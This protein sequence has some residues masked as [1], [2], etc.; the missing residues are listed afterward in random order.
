MKNAY[1][2]FWETKEE[3][4]ANPISGKIL[5][6]ISGTGVTRFCWSSKTGIQWATRIFARDFFKVK[7]GMSDRLAK[8]VFVNMKKRIAEL[9]AQLSAKNSEK[10]A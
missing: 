3:A 5:Y 6:V 8:N 7:A 4:E 9:E 2:V 10:P 1:P